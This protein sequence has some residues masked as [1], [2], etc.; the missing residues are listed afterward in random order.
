MGYWRWP[1]ISIWP[2]LPTTP[3]VTAST[4]GLAVTR[5]ASARWPVSCLSPVRGFGLR[6]FMVM[7][8]GSMFALYLRWRCIWRPRRRRWRGEAGH[9]C[10][11]IIVDFATGFI[12]RRDDAASDGRRGRRHRYRPARLRSGSSL[13]QRLYFRVG[14]SRS[15]L[16]PRAVGARGRALMLPSLP[17]CRFAVLIV[18]GGYAF[19]S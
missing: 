13:A 15:A 12:C 10:L 11:L 1:A 3:T 18:Y 9:Y 7:V 8:A 19:L 4:G 6:S 17:Q 2:A 14:M 5:R 16:I